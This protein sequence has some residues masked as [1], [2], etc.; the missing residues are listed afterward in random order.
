VLPIACVTK[1]RAGKELAEMSELARA[2]AVA[3]SDDGSPVA[4]AGMMRRA[5]EYAG[6]L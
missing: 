6:M 4:D 3:F 5:L 1:G 2:G